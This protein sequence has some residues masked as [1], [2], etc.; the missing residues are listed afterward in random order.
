MHV[1][2]LIKNNSL[3]KFMYTKQTR[4]K[5][6]VNPLIFQSFFC[7][8]LSQ[9]IRHMK[10]KNKRK[11][12]GLTKSL[13]NMSA[14]ISRNSREKFKFHN[15]KIDRRYRTSKQYKALLKEL[16]EGWANDSITESRINEIIRDTNKSRRTWLAS[17]KDRKV[18]SI[19]EEFPCFAEGKYVSIFIRCGA[20]CFLYI[21]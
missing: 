3:S 16:S 15:M 20:M 4:N 11:S 6:T 12:M 19:I 13:A 17:H 10:W 1:M 7:K 18:F 14:K 8:S 21:K 9:K 2:E 5:S